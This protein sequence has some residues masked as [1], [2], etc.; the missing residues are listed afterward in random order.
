MLVKTFPSKCRFDISVAMRPPLVYIHYHRE[1]EQL[2][3]FF[4]WSPSRRYL[5]FSRGFQQLISSNLAMQIAAPVREQRHNIC[6]NI[7]SGNTER[8]RAS[9]ILGLFGVLCGTFCLATGVFSSTTLPIWC[10]S[11][12][13]LARNRQAD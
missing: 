9:I 2:F 11:R 7:M 4:T 10:L 8:V 5:S 6:P 13:N 12:W 3:I 1:R